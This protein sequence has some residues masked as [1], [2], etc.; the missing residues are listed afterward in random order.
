MKI[1]DRVKIVIG[2]PSF[3]LDSKVPG[4]EGEIVYACDGLYLVK[5]DWFPIPFFTTE[6]D[7]EVLS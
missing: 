1:G 5:V 7:L 2:A 4:Q 6:H 3:Y